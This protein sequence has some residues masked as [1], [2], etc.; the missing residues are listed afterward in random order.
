MSKHAKLNTIRIIAGQWRGRRLGVPD[1]D[2][3]RPTTDRVRETL[4]NWLMHDIVGARCL[5]LFAGSGA[6]GLESY[7]RGAQM[8]E[9]IESNS[10]AIENLHKNITA[11]NKQSDSSGIKVVQATAQ[12]YLSSPPSQAFD[13]VFL[14]P[15]YGSELLATTIDQLVHNKWL[16]ANAM[17]YVEQASTVAELKLTNDW[18]KHRQGRAGRSAFYLYQ[19]Q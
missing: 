2:G 17:V 9:L 19:T 11:L 13:I 16:A 1:L 5:D 8:V 15:P 4:F 10:K 14:D 6:L 18:I 3:L 7:S 12:D